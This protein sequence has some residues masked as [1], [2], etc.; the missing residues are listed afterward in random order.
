MKKTLERLARKRRVKTLPPVGA[1]IEVP[2]AALAADQL[3]RVADF[4]SIGTND[5]T[6]YTLAADRGDR[7]VARYYDPLHPALLRL[8][9]FSTE[10][11]RRA[12][13]PIALCGEMAGDP[14]YAALLIGLGLREFSMAPHS[15]PRVKQRIRALDLAVATPRAYS[16]LEQ[17]DSG[18]IAAILD[19]LNALF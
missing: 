16:M 10:A 18:R 5:L 12:G 19:D 6:M 2:A 15:L 17:R 7:R 11:A 8:I 14:R 4:F 3:A 9:Q 13:I 1:M